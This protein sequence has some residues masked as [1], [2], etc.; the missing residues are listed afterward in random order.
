PILS[1]SAASA[2]INGPCAASGTIGAQN[3]NASQASAVIPRRG[4]VDWKGSASTGSGTRNIEGKVYP[5]LP[6][7]VGKLVVANGAWTVPPSVRSLRRRHASPLA[8]RVRRWRTAHHRAAHERAPRTLVGGLV[9]RPLPA[10]RALGRAAPAPAPA[11][12]GDGARVPA[13]GTGGTGS[14]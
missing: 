11:A 5:K 2:T 4:T 1:A 9:A 10:Q 7:P 14:C 3:Y 12:A 13:P 8:H 6:P